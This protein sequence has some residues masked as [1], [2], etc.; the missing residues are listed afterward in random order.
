MGIVEGCSS[1]SSAGA[2][3][4]G[5]SAA[6]DAALDGV[7]HDSASEAES[8]TD[9]TVAESGPESGS[10]EGSS[11][12]GVTGAEGGGEAAVEAGVEG[13]AEA[14]IEAGDE[15]D[16]EAGPEAGPEASVEAAVEASVEAGPSCVDLTVKNFDDWCLFGVNGST[17]A[18]DSSD[19][20]CVSPGTATV[21]AQAASGFILGP[22]PWH[23][24]S[25]DTGS[26]DPGTVTG[27]G[28]TAIDTTTVVVGSA[29]KCIWVCC[30]F[31]GGSGCPTTD[32]CP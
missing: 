11:S 27:S 17:L 22:A 28:Q 30:P 5:G 19:T 16:D 2:T 1:S 20:F 12:S 7:G 6:H 29:A 25:G 21:A 10:A 9:G 14:G 8:G 24:T 26:G 32:F 3:G 4:D 31:P 18:R 13:G 15:A 23:D